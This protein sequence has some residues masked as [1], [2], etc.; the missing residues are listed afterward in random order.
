MP[1]KDAQMLP[2]RVI[3]EC[4]GVVFFYCGGLR[5]ERILDLIGSMF[6]SKVYC[7]RGSQVGLGTQS[8]FMMD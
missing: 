4:V 2:F 8:P 6:R 1:A 7:G 3:L 5:R